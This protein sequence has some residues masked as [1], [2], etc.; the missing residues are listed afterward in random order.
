MTSG[1][2]DSATLA[3]RLRLMV[4]TRPDPAGGSLRDVVAECVDAGA[5]AIQLRDKRASTRELWAT[6]TEL[7][8]IVRS[9]GALFLINDR[10][11]VAIAV[12]ADGVHLGP[13]DLPLAAVRREVPSGFLVGFSTDEPPA[14]RR[15]EAD[16]ADYLGVGAVFGTTSKAGLANEA[17][18]PARVAEVAAAVR[19]PVVAVGGVNSRNVASVVRL[20]TGVAVLAA[21]MDSARPGEAVRQ[22]ERAMHLDV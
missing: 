2:Q 11:D 17:I 21:V 9:A 18:G 7:S 3:E 14:A 15:A 16:G 10:F 4:I 12:A 6:A 13:E 19:L 1:R 8:P 5:T 20:G 22:L